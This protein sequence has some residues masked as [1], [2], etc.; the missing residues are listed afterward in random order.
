MG[1]Q[2]KQHVNFLQ[3][4]KFSIVILNRTAE[5]LFKEEQNYEDYL[6]RT[7]VIFATPGTSVIPE[8]SLRSKTW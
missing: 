2:V 5:S 7:L 6:K 4:C 1:G 3:V 8:T